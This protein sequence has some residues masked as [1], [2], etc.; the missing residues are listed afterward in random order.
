MFTQFEETL[1]FDDVLLVPMKSAVLPKETEISTRLTKK[2]SLKIPL[3]SSPMDT[4]TECKMAIAL[5]LQGGIGII[6]KNLTPENQAKEVTYVKRF[7]NGFIENPVTLQP[8]DKIS[9]V[10]E[11]KN[12]KGY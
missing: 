4:V 10:A 2:I 11:I 7:E 9:E 1:T 8:E 12:T 6:H 3:L 5:A